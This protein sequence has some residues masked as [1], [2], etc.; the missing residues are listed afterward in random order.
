MASTG[1]DTDTEQQAV[2]LTLRRIKRVIWDKLGIKPVMQTEGL[3]DSSTRV[4]IKVS[5]RLLETDS[6]PVHSP[7][8]IFARF[9]PDLSRT[10]SRLQT[11]LRTFLDCP[12][13]LVDLDD[14]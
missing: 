13:F 11:C 9:A 4:F 6:S 12:T 1:P 10:A 3:S 7:R 5:V 14:E 8:K 2:G